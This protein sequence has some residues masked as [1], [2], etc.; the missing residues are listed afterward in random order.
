MTVSNVVDMGEV[1]G[2]SKPYIIII[3]LLVS[4]KGSF[5]YDL[6]LFIVWQV[7]YCDILYSVKSMNTTILD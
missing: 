6:R 7:C 2:N 1:K 4:G 5:L 3:G